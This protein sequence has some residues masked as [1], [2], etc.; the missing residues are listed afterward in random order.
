MRWSLCVSCW[1]RHGS[2]YCSFS[3][4][5]NVLSLIQ[6]DWVLL[7]PDQVGSGFQRKGD[8]FFSQKML[9]ALAAWCFSSA[10]KSDSPPLTSSILWAPWAGNG[11]DLV[12]TSFVKSFG[13]KYMYISLPVESNRVAAGYY[14]SGEKLIRI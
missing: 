5:E 12:C 13:I 1:K 2:N 6:P 10:L 11:F 3:R 4:T 14:L 7:L 8:I 9:I